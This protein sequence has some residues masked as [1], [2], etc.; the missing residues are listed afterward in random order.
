MAFIHQSADKLT[1]KDYVSSVVVHSIGISCSV[2]VEVV[3]INALLSTD[4]ITLKP[5]FLGNVSYANPD[6]VYTECS[7]MVGAYADGELLAPILS[8][9]YSIAN[10]YA[11]IFSDPATL[12]KHYITHDINLVI[13][14]VPPKPHI[15]RLSPVELIEVQNQITKYLEEGWVFS[16]ISVFGVP[17]CFA[18]K[19]DRI[20]RVCI[21]YRAFIKL[22][23]KE[24]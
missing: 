12:P 23:I 7:H 18:C 22:T 15:Y 10:E 8:C 11:N 21:D 3:G 5:V 13:G 6:I 1:A 17:I 9:W 14:Y 2:L 19:R 4:Q 24:R 16:S 20:L